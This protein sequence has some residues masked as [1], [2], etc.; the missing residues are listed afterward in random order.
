M[1]PL[2]MAFDPFTPIPAHRGAPF[3]IVQEFHNLVREIDRIVRTGVER[4]PLSSYPSFAE[5]ELDDG[6]PT[7]IY[8][9]ISIMVDLSFIVL[10]SSELMHK[11]AVL[12]NFSSISSDTR[13]AKV[14]NSS[15]LRSFASCR[16]FASAEPL[17]TTSAHRSAY[18]H[19]SHD[20]L[21]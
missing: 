6:F 17:P 3:R 16:M 4:C 20:G 15:T 19:G 5:I 21:P 12:R 18:I 2:Q 8:S 13:P 9:I 11:S 1:H 10:Y 14:K 7:A